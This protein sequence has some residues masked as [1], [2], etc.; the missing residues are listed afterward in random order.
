MNTARMCK[1]KLRGGGVRSY[2]ADCCEKRVEHSLDAVGHRLLHEHGFHLPSGEFADHAPP[3]LWILDPEQGVRK[4]Q[5]GFARRGDEAQ[6][7]QGSTLSSES[8]GNN[9]SRSLAFIDCVTDPAYTVVVVSVANTSSVAVYIYIYVQES[10]EC[11][12]CRSV[13]IVLDGSVSNGTEH[14]PRPCA[15]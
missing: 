9:V 12:F 6:H 8:L 7:E 15:S 13:L 10:R 14:C 1:R 11:V 2:Q 3:H 5:Q 4:G